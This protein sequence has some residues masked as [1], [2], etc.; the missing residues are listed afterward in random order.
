MASQTTQWILELIDKVT[1]PMR[2]VTQSADKGQSSFEKMRSTMKDIS[3]IDMYAI[4]NSVQELSNKLNQAAAP[5]AAFDAQLKDVQAITGVAGEGLERLGENARKTAK[6]FG[7]DASAQMESY[8]GILS[9]FGPD[10]AKNENALTQM[11]TNVATLSKTMKNDAVGSMDALTTS[12][13]QFGVDLSDPTFAASEMT[14]MMNVMAAGAKEGASE[15][16]QISEALKQAGVQALNSKVSFEETNAAL[17]ALAQ[18]GKF[19]SEAGVAL[20][21]VLGKMAGIDVVPKDAAGKLK[22][23]GVNYDIVSDKSLP[24]VDR[25]RELAKAQGDG[26]IMAQIF[27]V[28][29]AAAAQILIRSTEYQQNLTT[30]ITG[31]NVAVEQ[32]NI[33]MSSYNEKMAR[34]KAWVSDLGIGF[35]GVTKNILPFI[36]AGAGAITILAQMANAKIGIMLLFSVFKGFPLIGGG[37]SLGFNAMSLA[38]KGFSAAIYSIPIVGWIA[39]A[40]AAIAALVA[41]FYNA[42]AKTRGILFGI[43]NFIKVVFIGY[44][45]FIWEV[46][47]GIWHIIQGVFNPANWFNKNYKISDGFTKIADAAKEY[48]KNVGSAFAEGRAAGESSYN[49]AHPDEAPRMNTG[50]KS[51]VIAPNAGGAQPAASLWGGGN[52]FGQQKAFSGMVPKADD[53]SPIAQIPKSTL[54]KETKKETTSAAGSGGLSGSGSSGVRTVNQRIDMKNYFNVSGDSDVESI[55]TKV[56]QAITRQLQDGTVAV[57]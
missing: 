41:Y 2:G 37:V 16:P 1:G 44:Y 26:T 51:F 40:I 46:M 38:A 6:I 45:K 56:V 18:G 12:V 28:E 19:G 43:G 15:V 36:T 33:V 48:G 47:K 31:T 32:A 22:Q 7:G 4:A 53:Q 3:A 23:L 39:L 35:F 30:K 25:L 29:N 20:R 54:K 11:G 17:Q 50:G 34:M 52:G 57:A 21:N 49:N 24:L 14:R 42:S 55:A 5:G 27:G 10:I 13:L 8:K 9:R